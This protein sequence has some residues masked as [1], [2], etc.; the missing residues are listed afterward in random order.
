MEVIFFS[1][2]IGFEK[3][4]RSF[5]TI[6][7]QLFLREQIHKNGN[8]PNTINVFFQGINKQINAMSS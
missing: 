3:C 7:F 4:N 8:N 1:K 5:I 2:H 6:H